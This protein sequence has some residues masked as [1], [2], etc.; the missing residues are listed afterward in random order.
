MLPILQHA[1]LVIAEHGRPLGFVLAVV[2]L[3]LLGGGLFLTDTPR[4]EV[5][6]TSNPLT[7]TAQHTVTAPVTTDTAAYDAGDTLTDRPVYPIDA[8]PNAT[9][10]TNIDAPQE[11]T[12]TT[13]TYLRYEAR[14]EDSKDPFFTDTRELN[15]STV[16]AFDV[17][18]RLSALQ[19][20]FGPQVNVTATVVT[21]VDYTTQDY[22][23]TVN[24]SSQ[25]TY[26]S[27]ETYRIA[28]SDATTTRRTSNVVTQVDQSRTIGSTSVGWTT[29]VALVL[30]CVLLG[31]G[32]I[33]HTFT[34]RLSAQQE[35]ARLI[36]SRYDVNITHVDGPLSC[37]QPDEYAASLHE[38]VKY[39][40]NTDRAVLKC[41]AKGVYVV[42]D[43]IHVIAYDPYDSSRGGSA[44]DIVWSDDTDVV[45]E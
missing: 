37:P 36:E 5:T 35:R 30:G 39:A 32:G 11:P 25:L 7:I 29:V 10:T 21:R 20:E 18:N 26:P 8:A 13:T 15:T 38:L 19:E 14:Y 6:R 3:L 44:P 2:G 28:T 4:E 9:I 41:R 43:D 24:V 16:N 31:S 23:G 22:D 17:R 42:E 34:S 12:T 33:A 1:R 45:E 27:Q 40:H